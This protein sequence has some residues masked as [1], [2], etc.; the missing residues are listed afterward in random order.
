MLFP[1]LVIAVFAAS[2][3]ASPISSNSVVHE[4]RSILS[5]T[6]GA[7]VDENAIIPL[8][9]GLKQTNLDHGYDAVMD[10]SE[11]TSPNYGKWLFHEV[12]CDSMG[13]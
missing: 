2:S 5:T 11:P 4:K 8:R 12:Q 13:S 6:K 9:I 7:R 10:V 1:T 3:L